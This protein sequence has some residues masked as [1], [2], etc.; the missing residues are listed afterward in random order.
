M[1]KR[2]YSEDL[3]S[4]VLKKAIALNKKVKKNV[5]DLAQELPVQELTLAKLQDKNID[6]PNSVIHSFKKQLAGSV[7]IGLFI[8]DTLCSGKLNVIL[9]VEYQKSKFCVAK[10]VLSVLDSVVNGFVSSNIVNNSFGI[11][12]IGYLVKNKIISSDYLMIGMAGYIF[13]GVMMIKV[14]PQILNTVDTRKKVQITTSPDGVCLDMYKKINGSGGKCTSIMDCRSEMVLKLRNKRIDSTQYVRMPVLL[15]NFFK[16]DNTKDMNRHIAIWTSILEKEVTCT[17][18]FGV[19]VYYSVAQHTEGDGTAWYKVVADLTL[20]ILTG[21]GLHTFKNCI[22]SLYLTMYSGFQVKAFAKLVETV[23]SNLP[24]EKKAIATELFEKLL[25]FQT[26]MDEQ[27]FK[28]GSP[29]LG[30]RPGRQSSTPSPSRPGRSSTPSPSR[31]GRSSTP[32]PSRQSRSSVPSPSSSTPSPS[33]PRPGRTS[34]PSPSSST[35][36]PSRPRPGR[37]SVPSPSSS[38]PSPSRQSRQSRSRVVSQ[39]LIHQV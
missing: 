7:P 9:P 14:L 12:M 25:E 5:V 8:A 10:K 4:P 17:S 19:M 26:L 31:P 18:D 32:S 30:T 16:K 34:V 29:R 11:G 35:P 21:S 23:S 2:K 13:S 3:H 36:S 28:D 37:T 20:K 24:L 33:R 1:F 39:V 15:Y 6:I 22:S 27:Q 38:T